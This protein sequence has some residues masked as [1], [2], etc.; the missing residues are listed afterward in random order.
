MKRFGE[1]SRERTARS[2]L[3]RG[4]RSSPPLACAEKTSQSSNLLCSTKLRLGRPKSAWCLCH[5][6]IVESS[7]ATDCAAITFLPFFDFARAPSRRA[8]ALR[9]G[10]Q[11]LLTRAYTIPRCERRRL[12]GAGSY[13]TVRTILSSIAP[14]CS[15]G[16]LLLASLT[17]V[18]YAANEWLPQV[19]RCPAVN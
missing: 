4:I 12:V 18:T 13:S 10:D 7:L 3:V 14:T 6:T 5:Y 15:D 17:H 16:G 1:S 8:V 9:T 2:A 19:I 11:S